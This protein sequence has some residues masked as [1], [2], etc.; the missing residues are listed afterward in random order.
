M[1]DDQEG[2]Q[3]RLG[4]LFFICL[5]LAYGAA[6]P[7]INLFAGEKYIVIRERASGAYTTSAYYVSK[8]VA[9]LPKLSS[10]LVFCAL[11]YWIVGFNPDP[12]RFLNFVLIILAEVLSAQGVGMVRHGDPIGAALALGPAFITVFT[13]FA[14][15]YLNMD[16]I[17]TGAGWVRYIDFI[18]Y[19][20]S[21]LMANEFRDPDAIFA[22]QTG[23]TR[24]SAYLTGQL[25]RDVQPKIF[26]R[27]ADR[28]PAPLVRGVTTSGGCLVRS[29]SSS[30]LYIEKADPLRHPC[31]EDDD[32]KNGDRVENVHLQSK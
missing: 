10:K 23:R 21:A 31:T 14:G 27:A 25:S 28:L 18:W 9:E 12:T 17:P 19:A 15:I 5:N 30:Y 1:E 20:Y 32:K 24:R 16:S 4:C 2:L 26:A 22:C 3:N 7:S 8:L 29:S 13:L 11:V 6:L